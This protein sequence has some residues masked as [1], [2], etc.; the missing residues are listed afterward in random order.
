[1]GS[2]TSKGEQSKAETAVYPEALAVIECQINMSW[3]NIMSWH[4]MHD[5]NINFKKKV[6][7][8]HEDPF[9]DINTNIYWDSGLYSNREEGGP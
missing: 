3:Q 2:L 4:A 1:M 6:K 8:P 7:N 5:I 9:C